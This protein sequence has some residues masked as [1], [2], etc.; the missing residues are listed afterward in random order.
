VAALSGHL[1][2]ERLSLIR[3][4]FDSLIDPLD[5]GLECNVLATVEKY[6]G[7]HCGMF[8]LCARSHP[9][10]AQPFCRGCEKSGVAAGPS[11]L[12]RLWSRDVLLRFWWPQPLAPATEVELSVPLPAQFST[13]QT[14]MLTPWLLS[15]APLLANITT[16][17]APP[18]TLASG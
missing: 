8:P 4:R 2:S 14:P 3:S 10:T 7:A 1:Q 9:G 5:W 12:G 11:S 13:H 6:F 15:H 16:V 18:G 17:S